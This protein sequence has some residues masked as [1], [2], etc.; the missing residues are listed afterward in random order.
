VTPGTMAPFGSVTLPVMVA[1]VLWAL[2]MPAAS[3]AT[4]QTVSTRHILVILM[5]YLSSAFA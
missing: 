5:T 3:I 1:N 4:R 2:A